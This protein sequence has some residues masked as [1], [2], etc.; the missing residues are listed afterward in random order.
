MPPDCPHESCYP[1]IPA[2]EITLLPSNTII[3][4]LSRP[5]GAEASFPNLHHPHQVLVA[6]LLEVLISNKLEDKLGKCVFLT[7]GGIKAKL[8]CHQSSEGT[9]AQPP[10][11]HPRL[12]ATII[13]H[14]FNNPHISHL[15]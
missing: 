7:S 11:S 10:P 2:A 15:P 12:A 6:R 14:H 3:N 1:L 8:R 13:G 5:I 4:E 9:T